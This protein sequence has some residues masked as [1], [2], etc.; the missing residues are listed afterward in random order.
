MTLHARHRLVV[1]DQRAAGR[2]CAGG[3]GRTHDEIDWQPLL[4]WSSRGAGG[5]RR[6][7][8]AATCICRPT[9]RGRSSSRCSAS[10]PPCRCA[11]R[12]RGSSH[13]RSLSSACWS[14]RRLAYYGGLSGVLHAGVAV[15]AVQLMIEGPRR[16][17]WIGVALLAGLGLKL[18]SEA[19][20]DGPCS[21]RPASTSRPCQSH[22]RAA[23][24]RDCLPACCCSA[25]TQRP[26]VA[27][28]RN[29]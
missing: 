2:R 29:G 23:R 11:P 21:I 4:A 19:P 13:G 16:R 28:R 1:W 14:N 27:T 17:R 26:P 25:C 12:W 22:M 10:R 9:L 18:I 5:A 8:T 24:C 20:W 3:H 7:C 15:V 6:G